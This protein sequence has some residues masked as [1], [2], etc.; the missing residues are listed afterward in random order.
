MADTQVTLHASEPTA[1]PKPSVLLVDDQPA[2]LTALRAILDDLGPELVEARSG[3]EALDRLHAAEF[4]V[5]LLDVNM[6]GR[7]GFETARLIRAREESRH[8]PIIYVTAFDADRAQVE[9]AYALGAVDFLFKPLSPVIVRAKV[10]GF[11]DLFEKARRIR[12]LERRAFERQLAEGDERLRVQREW[13]RTTLHSIGDAVIATDTEGRVAFLNP[14]AESLTGWR[15]D[16]AAGRPLEEVFVIVNEETRRPVENPVAK[17][18]REGV[19][20]GLAN[21]TVLLAKDRREVPIDDSAAPIRGEGGAVGGVVMVFRDVTEARRAAEARLRLAALVDSS[22]DAIIGKDLGGIV[23]SWNAAAER[24]FGYT[25]EEM[26]GQPLARLVLPDQPDELPAIMERL[27]RGERVE[28]FETVRVRKDG[29]RVAVSLTI[30]PIKDAEGKVVGAS[31]IARDVTAQK[32]REAELRFLAGASDALAELT[33]VPDTL[34]KVAVL[35][36]PHFADWCAVDLAGP[37]GQLE[38][39]AGAH[40]DADMVVFGRAFHRRY[41]PRR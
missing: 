16:E 6:P 15:A 4:A 11:V 19:I 1:E 36:V 13:L 20:V 2:N 26:V 28:H 35:A 29:T 3:E 40:A 30:S 17:V 14:V 23:T 8:T 39:V 34:Q 38:R 12:Q 27:K 22:N 41:P 21:H 32:R 10:A 24:L 7:D 25:A 33:D 5:I 9:R 31:K 37:D 18:L